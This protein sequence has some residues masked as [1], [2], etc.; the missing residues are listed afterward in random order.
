MLPQRMVFGRVLL[1]F[2][3][4]RCRD[5]AFAEEF[6][7]RMQEQFRSRRRICQYRIYE[8]TGEHGSAL[9]LALGQ[10]VPV[11]LCIS[12]PCGAR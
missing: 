5:V 6:S 12:E 7:V 11:Q 4:V 2:P 9:S 3:R 8:S 1:L 10:P